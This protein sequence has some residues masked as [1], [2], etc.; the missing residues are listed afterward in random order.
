MKKAWIGFFVCFAAGYATFAWRD[1]GSLPFHE[2]T[3]YP[4]GN[5]ESS[6]RS[7]DIVNVYQDLMMNDKQKFQLALEQANRLADLLGLAEKIHQDAKPDDSF[8]G[9]LT[10]KIARLC[11][12]QALNF[13][14]SCPTDSGMNAEMYANI[15]QAWSELNFKSCIA[16]LENKPPIFCRNFHDH[17]G[18]LA[19]N[20]YEL[21][22]QECID[23]FQGFSAEMQIQ[24]M[25]NSYM[26][27]KL[28]VLL[29]PLVKDQ[30]FVAKVKED[31]AK[32]EQIE[33][34]RRQVISNRVDA[35]RQ[36]SLEQLPSKIEE[37]KDAWEN[38]W[39]ST[40]TIV[41]AIRSLP[42][43]KEKRDLLAWVTKPR[44]TWNRAPDEA[45]QVWL[46]RIEQVLQEVGDLP[47]SLIEMPLFGDQ[48]FRD[49][50]AGWLP[51]QSPALQRAWAESV[52]RFQEPQEA[53]AWIEKLSTESLRQDMRD[54]AWERWTSNKGKDAAAALMEQATTEECEMHL[55]DAV[56]GWA[57]WDYAAA[58]QWLDAQPDSEAK[59]QALQKIEA[60]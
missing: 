11:P 34:L 52:V 42:S 50:L 39:P 40:E 35:D 41:S 15:L 44:G 36:K 37:W 48:P 14:E 54:L 26:D 31:L 58:K 57:N 21:H 22:P 17:W 12:E 32:K 46:Q 7:E 27:E 5:R 23:V 60:K 38:A 4:I 30:L 43:L 29:L 45:P 49:V 24:L 55:P 56:H 47:T 25:K 1:D 51:Q 33:E 19:G 59:N 2:V 6:A 3:E 18:S 20:R 9:L 10:D 53:F 28:Y 13:Y 16:Y 8:L